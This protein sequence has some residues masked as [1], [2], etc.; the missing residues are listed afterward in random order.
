MADKTVG[1]DV[2]PAGAGGLQIKY[3][4]NGDGT[5]SEQVYSTGSGGG[6]GGAV[7]MASG[8]VASGAFSSGSVATG[9]FA[10]G[11]VASGAFAAG[12]LASGAVASGAYAAG[13]IVDGADITQGAKADA[14]NTDST[15]AWSVI[16]LL[17]GLWAAITAGVKL[18]DAAG[19]N[20][21]T[22]K[23]A[24]TA[25]VASTDTSLVTQALLG[26]SLV[27]AGIALSGSTT[28]GASLSLLAVQATQTELSS[29][30]QAAT[31]GTSAA[32][33]PTNGIS[34]QF[35]LNVSTFTAGSSTGY[36]AIL[37]YSLDGQTN[38]FDAWHFD[39]VTASGFQVTPPL[40]I[41]GYP[42]RISWVNNT[43]A[44]TTC[45]VSLLA[46]RMPTPVGPAFKYIDRTAAL[47]TNP[48]ANA[49]GATFRVFG[50]KSITTA[51]TVGT[52]ATPGQYTIQ[53]SADGTNWTSAVNAA[54]TAASV[55]CVANSTVQVTAVNV[56]HSYVRLIQ[57]ASSVSQTGTQATITALG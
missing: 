28:Q 5:F 23:A 49:V 9:A 14:A 27:Q 16:A 12:A 25:A 7:T 51:I 35:T 22:I 37:Q 3:H 41:G 39:R 45:T 54:G 11:S 38:W 13:A 21:A 36:D 18:V 34:S 42:R 43:G 48:A 53:T 40:N 32:I 44:A 31:S 15:S 57:T 30:N 55:T 4:D 17:K 1:L 20:K 19:T 26:S 56:T 47:L 10:S 46:T 50:A 2:L 29:V 6:G 8:A 33:V 24:A 52:A